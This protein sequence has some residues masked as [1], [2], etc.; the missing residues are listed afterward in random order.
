MIGAR[1]RISATCCWVSWR[2]TASPSRVI[3]NAYESPIVNVWLPV[4]KARTVGTANQ[5]A[6]AVMAQHQVVGHVRDGRRVTN[7]AFYGEEELVLGGGQAHVACRRLTPAQE[8]PQLL[9][10]LEQSLVVGLAGRCHGLI[11]ACLLAALG[12]LHH[13]AAGACWLA[14]QP[15]MRSFIGYRTGIRRWLSRFGSG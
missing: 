2:K 3:V 10:E 6:D 11:Q 13:D 14:G 4:D 12:S 1:P 15:P 7:M 8:P 9:A 5:F